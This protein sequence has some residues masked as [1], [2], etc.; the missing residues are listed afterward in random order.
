MSVLR[1]A[2]AA[3]TAILMLST[4][5]NPAIAAGKKHG[6]NDFVQAL[7]SLFNSEH[8]G[9]GKHH[10][11][12]KMTYQDNPGQQTGS[13]SN[14]IVYF[15]T[16]LNLA[17]V[18]QAGNAGADGYCLPYESLTGSVKGATSPTCTV[19]TTWGGGGHETPSF[20]RGK[21]KGGGGGGSK[22][23]TVSGT[24]AE[25][26]AANPPKEKP[27]HEDDDEYGGDR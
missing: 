7:S 1:M 9:G 26:Q 19:T 12:G 17:G 16:C 11:F 24:C 6:G 15:G 10:H 20:A 21:S 5:S 4:L 22:T 23:E 3:S 25:Y 2:C 14:T 27:H 18:Q 13:D 8:N